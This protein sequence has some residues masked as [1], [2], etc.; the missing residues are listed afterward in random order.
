MKHDVVGDLEGLT[1]AHLTGPHDVRGKRVEQRL[2]PLEGGLV[3]PGHYC[4][5][6][7]IRGGT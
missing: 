3:A 6:P 7:G 1:R 5:R 2:K 4:Q